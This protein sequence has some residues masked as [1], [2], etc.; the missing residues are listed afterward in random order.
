MTTMRQL[1]QK[2]VPNAPLSAPVRKY[3]N[4]ITFVDGLRFDSA[5]E[6]R[7]WSE[8][9]LLERAGDITNLKRQVQFACEVN[10]E[11]VCKYIADF[12]YSRG[13]EHI[14]EDTKGVETAL[15]RLKAKLM[16]ACHGVT[17][18]LGK[19]RR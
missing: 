17:V 2:H 14:V 1:V 3:K 13:K 16:H 6:A 7:R 10:G 4:R 5:A 9:K 8:L 15:F 19:V 12:T 11:P 18:Q